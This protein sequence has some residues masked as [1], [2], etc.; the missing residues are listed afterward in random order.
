[1]LPIVVDSDTNSRTDRTRTTLQQ[2]EGGL[3]DIGLQASHD[4]AAVTREVPSLTFGGLP[5]VLIREEQH[6]NDLARKLSGRG[7]NS[8]LR[9]VS[10]R[11]FRIYSSTLR[12]TR[13]RLQTC[14]MYK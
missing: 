3:Q 10:L 1:M 6:V 13:L 14:F 7:K 5:V 4:F 8:N 2:V 9:A 11:V 12:G